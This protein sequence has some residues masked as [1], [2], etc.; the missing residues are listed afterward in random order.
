MEQLVAPLSYLALTPIFLLQGAEPYRIWIMSIA[1]SALS[2][3]L[4]L[5]Y[6]AIQVRDITTRG[7][8]PLHADFDAIQG[9]A[10]KVLLTCAVVLAVFVAVAVSLNFPPMVIFLLSGFLTAVISELDKFVTA[11]SRSEQKYLLVFLSEVVGRLAW[12]AV[13]LLALILDTQNIALFVMFAFAARLLCKVIL[14]YWSSSGLRKEYT[15]YLSA[16]FRGVLLAA[17]TKW[18]LLQ[19]LGGSMITFADRFILGAVTSVDFFALYFPMFQVTNL[20]F[21]FAASASTVILSSKRVAA[22][23]LTQVRRYWYVVV[24]ASLP[25][26]SL[27][28]IGP[29]LLTAWLSNVNYVV[30]P[31]EFAILNT[32]FLFLS[33]LAPFHFFFLRL[34]FDREI[35]LTNNGSGVIYLLAMLFI[36]AQNENAVYLIRLLQPSVQFLIFTYLL[37]STTTKINITSVGHTDHNVGTTG[38]SDTNT[39]GAREK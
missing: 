37:M 39:K 6:T 26:F 1:F 19:V 21:T 22:P 38:Q 4:T 35:S 31:V 2:H 16:P 3:F 23:S 5:G 7:S 30:P 10:L 24:L 28:F 32:S 13:S 9:S 20:A 33:V 12:V 14:V 34:G 17:H 11:R 29:P 27:Y 8:S 25:S 18:I 15:R 36:G